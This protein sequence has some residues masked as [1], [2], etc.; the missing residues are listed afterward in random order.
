MFLSAPQNFLFHFPSLW[1][2]CLR[3]SFIDKLYIVQSHVCRLYLND[4]FILFG[5]CIHTSFYCWCYKSADNLSFWTTTSS[6]LPSY[7]NIYSSPSALCSFTMIWPNGNIYYF[8]NW[9]SLVFTKEFMNLNVSG[10]FLFNISL[11]FASLTISLLT[12]IET[13]NRHMLKYLILSSYFSKS[14]PCFQLHLLKLHAT[15]F[16]FFFLPN[17]F[18]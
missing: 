3:N 13:L 8:S 17:L 10:I 11:S 6:S 7:F 12:K 15:I 14:L 18:L 5:F 16:L 1:N 2:I 4:V 9:N